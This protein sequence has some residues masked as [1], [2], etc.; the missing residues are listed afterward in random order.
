MNETFAIKEGVYW[1]GAKDPNLRVFDIIMNTRWGTT[2]NSYLI[3]D[4]K[5]VLIDGVKGYC[6][7]DLIEN[8]SQ[9]IDPSELDYVVVNHNEPDHSAALDDIL[10]LAPNAQVVTNSR[11]QMFLK[12]ILNRAVNFHIIKDGDELSLGK[13]TLKFIDA[14]FLHWP[15]TMFTYLK[16]DKMLF[17]CDVFGSHYCDVRMYDDG[18][19]PHMH[20]FMYYFS[21]I[22]SPF[23]AKVLEAMKKVHTLEIDIIAPSHGPILRSNPWQYVD[24]YE[25]LSTPPVKCSSTMK[26][27][28]CYVSA[29]GY[30]KM[31]ADSIADEIRGTEGFEVE[32]VDATEVDKAAVLAKI[33]AAQYVFF[34]SPTINQNLLEP[35]AEIITSICPIKNKGKIVASFG[36][37]GWSGEAI[38]MM[39]DMLS[40]HKQRV[41]Q[42]GYSTR[43]KPSPEALTEVKDFARTIITT[44]SGI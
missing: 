25:K 20:E 12:E 1:V 39:D 10:R 35:I 4:E 36:S 34:G 21:V 23:K 3:L 24:L 13:K 7:R 8:I 11:S 2:Y 42:P 6:T 14:P 38:K 31:L 22:M 32:V 19:G 16:E 15:D 41:V 40:A 27:L 37:F 29:Y 5:K 44:S 26:A 18:A 30:T 28:V 9:Y 33:E 17:S 43:F